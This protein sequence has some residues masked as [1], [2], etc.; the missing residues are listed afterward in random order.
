MSYSP[1]AAEVVLYYEQQHLCNSMD[2]NT[3]GYNSPT[4]TEK[5][6]VYTNV[7]C[8]RNHS[9]HIMMNTRTKREESGLTVVKIGNTIIWNEI[10]DH[11]LLVV[12]PIEATNETRLG[13]SYSSRGMSLETMQVKRGCEGGVRES[14]FGRIFFE[15]EK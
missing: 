7:F 15:R 3:G 5:I 9:I 2:D 6:N 8:H 12:S 14:G 4:I 1:S 11:E 10:I 13:G